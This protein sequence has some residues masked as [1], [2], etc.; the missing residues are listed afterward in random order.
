MMMVLSSCVAYTKFPEIPS[1]QAVKV[2]PKP[3]TP[4]VCKNIP[5]PP[6]VPKIVHLVI[7]DGNI[8][9]DAGGEKLLD[10]YLEFRKLVRDTWYAPSH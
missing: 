4:V 3:S 1:P 2:Q 7:E 10:N 5:I 9:A 8:T 6:Q